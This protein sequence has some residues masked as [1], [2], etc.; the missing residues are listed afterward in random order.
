[1]KAE[2][3]ILSFIAILIGLLVAG[4]AFY[5]YQTTKVVPEDGKKVISANIQATPTPA[6]TDPIYLTVDEPKE[7]A[8]ISKRSV[9]ISGKTKA[10]ATV[11]VSSEEQDQVATPSADGSFTLTHT[12]GDGTNIIEVTAIFAD[13]TEKTIQKTITYTS[14]EF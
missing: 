8:V 11:I 10:D 6:P 9:T 14:E 4:V 12:I 7:E 1:M 13:G 3:I 5:L 2:K